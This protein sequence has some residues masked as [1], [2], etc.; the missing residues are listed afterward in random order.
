M[1]HLIPLKPKPLS[2]LKLRTP[3]H[4]SQTTANPLRGGHSWLD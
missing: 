1:P 3:R 2:F 4:R